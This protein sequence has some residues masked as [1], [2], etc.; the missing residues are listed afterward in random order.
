MAKAASCPER[1]DL[2]RF[3]MG[4]LAEADALPLQQH[5]AKCPSCLDTL[6]SLEAD[7][8]LIAAVRAQRDVAERSE[9]AIV[10]GLV[11]RLSGLRPVAT[12]GAASVSPNDAVDC[13][14]LAAAQG[15]SEFG[16]LGVDRV[17]KILGA[18][19]MGIV[20]EDEDTR[21]KRR[22]ALK[23]MKPALA[24][25][26]SARLR[27]QREAEAIAALEHDHI[28]AIHQVGEDRGVPFLAMP[29]LKGESLQDR[30]DREG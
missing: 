18:G 11:A 26:E 3:L 21:L 15:A 30:L 4:R 20:F 7:D 16:W 12:R 19:G 25:N 1:D 2:E 10:E 5:L 24:A 6:H 14:F 17:V 27:F 9:D 22:V 8:T 23:V 28:I 29:L 13:G